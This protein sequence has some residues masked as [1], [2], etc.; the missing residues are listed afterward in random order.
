MRRGRSRGAAVPDPPRAAAAAHRPPPLLPRCFF[1]AIIGVSSVS[2][3]AIPANTIIAGLSAGAHAFTVI[4]AES[5]IESTDDDAT[6]RT[7]SG[8]VAVR[9]LGELR[10]DNV[11]FAYP[12]R[13]ERMVLQGITLSVKGAQKVAFV[14]ES[15]SGKSTIVQLLEV[16]WRRR[17][18]MEASRQRRSPPTNT[19]SI[20]ISSKKTSASVLLS[21]TERVSTENSLSPRVLGFWPRYFGRERGGHLKASNGWQC[22][23]LCGV[24][25]CVS[26]PTPD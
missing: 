16:G 25:V 2:D 21:S 5:V 14:G 23:S 9:T 13:P 10:F 26:H 18:G 19:R 6:A 3:A 1:A 15:G 7:L 8:A 17:F 24:A 4:E 20:Y 11:T 12:S 22:V